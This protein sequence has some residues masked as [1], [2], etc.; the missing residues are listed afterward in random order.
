M[1]HVF[2]ITA[3]KGSKR[4]VNKNFR[5]FQGNESL[6]NL[7]VTHAHLLRRGLDNK[8]KCPIIISTDAPPQDI[9]WFSGNHLE[10]LMPSG[11][12]YVTKHN[13][14]HWKR[15]NFPNLHYLRRPDELCTDEAKHIDVVQ[16]LVDWFKEQGNEDEYVLTLI[17]PTSPFRSKDAWEITS[18]IAVCY[19]EKGQFPIKNRWCYHVGRD[20]QGP[21]GMFYCYHIV[22]NELCYHNVGRKKLVDHDDYDDNALHYMDI[23]TEEDFLIAQ[24]LAENMPDKLRQTILPL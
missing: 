23:D 8:E 24:C 12:P 20:G 7:A 6:V 1:R 11:L 3:R 5:P 13:D 22:G 4:C 16:H 10:E 14:S 2:L 9:F 19:K 15:N 18:R 17:Q 21:S